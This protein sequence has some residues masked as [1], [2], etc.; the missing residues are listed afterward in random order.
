MP[1]VNGE[2]LKWSKNIK[3]QREIMNLRQQIIQERVEK[4]AR[5]LKLW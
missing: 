4:T 5:D 2:A 3:K 1:A